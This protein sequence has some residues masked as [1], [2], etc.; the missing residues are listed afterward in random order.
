MRGLLLFDEGQTADRWSSLTLRRPFGG[1]GTCRQLQ[2]GGVLPDAQAGQQRNL[3]AG[4][5]KRVVMLV[6][7][8]QVDL[9][10]PRDVFSQLLVGEGSER[11]IALDVAVEHQLGPG[12]KAHRHVGLSDRRKATR[13][14]IDELGRNE[15]VADLGRAVRYVLQTVVTHGW[16]TPID[17]LD[18]GGAAKKGPRPLPG[19]DTDDAS[20]SGRSASSSRIARIRSFPRKDPGLRTHP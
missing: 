20:P 17:V 9:P 6:G 11:V 18:L 15:L 13:D 12:K 16:H 10:E 1:M 19:A 5:F 3:A 14:G 7:T 4:K 8:V 2:H